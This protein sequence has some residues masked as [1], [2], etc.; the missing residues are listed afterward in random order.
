MLS[1]KSY[2]G[3]QTFH[4]EVLFIVYLN[5]TPDRDNEKYSLIQSLHDKA[6][7]NDTNYI[8]VL[9]IRRA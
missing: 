1:S 4:K 5:L 7:I 2:Y 3:L 9:L 6:N 8:M